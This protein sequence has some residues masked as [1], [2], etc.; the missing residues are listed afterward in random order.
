MTEN[1]MILDEAAKRI[2][3]AQRERDKA[4]RKLATAKR[5]LK[6]MMIAHTADMESYEDEDAYALKVWAKVERFL[7][8]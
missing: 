6:D 1:Q 2:V 4:R 3:K 5:L 7:A 8:A